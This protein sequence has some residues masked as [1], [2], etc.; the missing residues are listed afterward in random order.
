M[1]FLTTN[2]KLTDDRYSSFWKKINKRGWFVILSLS[3]MLIF[4]IAQEYNNQ[5]L[6]ENNNLTIKEERKKQDS[7]ITVGI[8]SGVKSSNRKLFSDLSTAFAEQGLKI[9]TLKKTIVKLEDIKPNTTNNYS[10]NDPVVRINSDGVFYKEKRNGIDI[11]GLKIMSVD[12][13]STNHKI[14]CYL[15]SEFSDGQYDLSRMNVFPQ[16]LKI[17]KDRNWECS[18]RNDVKADGNRI[19]I[20]LKG[21][22]TTLDSVKTY[23]VDDLYFYDKKDN[24]CSMLLNAKRNEILKIIQR[25]PENVLKTNEGS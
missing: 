20:Y 6:S 2:G 25:V 11:Y 1:T 18:F 24:K 21:S 10:Q 4:L 9:D 15:L 14:L 8:N 7:I 13:G 17:P 3:L 5:N 19:Y 12:A 16:S 22:Y 23:Q